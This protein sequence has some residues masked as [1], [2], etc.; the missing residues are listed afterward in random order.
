MRAI[1]FTRGGGPEIIEVVDIAEPHAGPGQVRVRV[2]ASDLNISDTFVWSDDF[3][4]E[5]GGSEGVAVAGWNVAGVVDEVGP[6]AEDRFSPGDAVIAMA[7]GFGGRGA[8]AQYVVTDAFQTVAAPEGRTAVESSTLLMNALTARLL[9]DSLRLA[10][11]AKLAVT[12][13]AGA[14]GAYLIQLAKV[15]GHHVI[16]DAKDEDRE[17]IESLGAD[18]VIPRGDD[19]AA[20]VLENGGPVDAAVDAANLGRS[21]QKAVA[22]GG[23]IGSPRGLS[24]EAERGVRWIPVNTSQWVN[25]APRQEVTAAMEALRDLAANGSLTLRVAGIH[26]PEEAQEAYRR[27]LAGGSRGRLVIAF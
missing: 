10:P 4:R 3:V 8:H 2:A 7:H 9:L 25:A 21:L 19:F 14:L 12:G 26:A 17:L 16:A 24:G 23:A 11:G 18:V 20:A 5:H 6:G 27:L 1:G 13:G 22:D 15:D